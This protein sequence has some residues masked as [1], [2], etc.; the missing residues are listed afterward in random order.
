M[1]AD[2]L[3]AAVALPLAASMPRDTSKLPPGIGLS[4]G[5]VCDEHAKD[6]TWSADD[7]FRYIMSNSIPAFPVLDYCPFGIGGLYC[8]AYKQC[9]SGEWGVGGELCVPEGSGIELDPNRPGQDWGQKAIEKDDCPNPSWHEAQCPQQ[10]IE[11]QG[12]CLEPFHF[13]YR[14]PV[15]AK[16]VAQELGPAKYNRAHGVALDGVDI[17]G[18][19]EAGGL[20]LDEANIVKD[21][22]NGHPTPGMADARYHYHTTPHCAW[23][24]DNAN[25]SHY[26]EVPTKHSP[27]L[28]WE[29]DGFGLFGHQD[30]GGSGAHCTITCADGNDDCTDDC[31]GSSECHCGRGWPHRVSGSQKAD[32]RVLV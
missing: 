24:V 19:R 16:P 15:V 27:Q 26:V 31:E 20:S 4:Q 3:L 6:V 7:D 12:D 18:P 10:G 8:G 13:H 17:R 9:P 14:I 32:Q 2:T 1:R 23:S 5:V 21:K 22:C 28:G 30:E 11:D 25:G 29:F